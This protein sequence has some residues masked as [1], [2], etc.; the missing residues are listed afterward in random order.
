MPELTSALRAAADA[1]TADLAPIPAGPVLGRI[2]RRRTVRHASQGVVGV[3]A[4][5]A[6]AVGAT[7]VANRPTPP[8]GPTPTGLAEAL[9]VRCGAPLS[10]YVQPQGAPEVRVD[11][12]AWDAAFETPANA[13]YR[14]EVTAQVAPRD[15]DR[16]G[17]SV[18]VALVRGGVV[19]GLPVEPLPEPRGFDESGRHDLTLTADVTFGACGADGQVGGPLEPGLYGL[20]GFLE[21]DEP[22]DWP[23]P[24]RSDAV[25]VR[26]G[27]PAAADHLRPAF[28][29]LVISAEGLGPVRLGEPVTAAAETGMLRWSRAACVVL[30][31]GGQRDVAARESAYRGPGRGTFGV[32]V[33]DDV[34]RRVEVV[35]PGPRTPSGIGVGSTLEDVLAAHPDARLLGTVEGWEGVAPRDVWTVTEGGA[36]LAFEVATAGSAEPGTVLAIVATLDPYGNRIAT[37]TAC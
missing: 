30:D 26:L 27:E 5:G 18:G 16:V 10:D 37:G 3:A 1:A 15:A 24:V 32:R 4:A 17:R 34:V 6:I 7:Q 28:D 35:A 11:V 25:I 29:D 20:V 31:D 8:A 22:G 21:P 23:V 13:P 12:G 19:V 33:A 36:T 9:A 2:R 14:L